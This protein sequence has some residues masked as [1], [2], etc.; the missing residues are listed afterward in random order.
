MRPPL[1]LALVLLLSSVLIA[2]RV[3]RGI[4]RLDGR[5]LADESGPFNVLGTTLFW[6]LWGEQHD[7][8]RLDRN[9]AWVAARGVHYVRV[10]GMVGG[11][12][13]TDRL[14]DPAADD[15][16]PIVDRLLDRLAAHGLRAQVTLFAEADYVMPRR[17][18]RERFVDRWA[19][20]ANQ[21]PERFVMLEIANEHAQNG[22]AEVA[23]LRALGSRLARQTDVLVAF[24]SP[25]S[26]QECDVYA[27]SDADLATI[28]Y[29]RG[30]EGDDGPWAPVR[31]PWSWPRGFDASCRGQLPPAV[32]NEPIGPQSSV[33]HDDDPRRLAMAYVL[34]F[35][36][37][38]AAYVLHTGAGVRGGG[39]G[40][41]PRGRPANLFEVTKLNQT[42]AAIAA[43]QRYLPP[44][45]ANWDRLEPSS[46]R[47]PFSGIDGV[48]AGQRPPD[49]YA[50]AHDDRF[51]V[52]FLGTSGP[53]TLQ[54]RG[55]IEFEIRHALS[56]AVTSRSRLDK[57]DSVRLDG[58][59]SYVA[60]G[61]RL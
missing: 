35:V 1:V 29:G 60:I 5:A 40:D 50:S 47:F 52:A 39:I 57:G 24:S 21:R 43:A 54:A 31:Q 34:T 3:P 46:E 36:A 45:L 16:W 61:R 55:S 14:I 11:A 18:A 22:V 58:A 59:D 37:G 44:G 23:E 13:W 28:H 20:K 41:R 25:S 10:L 7:P 38:N 2:D 48:T 19:A 15:Y 4:V 8:D 26:G 30:A 51:V 53:L 42:L 56:G 27:G 12:S 17:D 49:V 32:N 33:A 6:A 9:L